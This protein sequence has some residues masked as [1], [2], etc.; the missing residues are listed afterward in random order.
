M[1]YSITPL[2]RRIKDLYFWLRIFEPW[3]ISMIEMADRLNIWL[4]FVNMESRVVG[5]NGMYSIIINSNQNPQEQWEDFGHEV[6]HLLE[7]SGNQLNLPLTCVK[8]Q[9]IQA[10]NF[11]LHFCIPTFMLTKFDLP[12]TVPTAA[13]F[14]SKTFNV[15]YRLAYW[16]LNHLQ[17][18]I[19]G[20]WQRPQAFEQENKEEINYSLHQ[21]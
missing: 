15:T 20:K 17:A 5:R 18:H 6:A 21:L 19:F 14:I 3:E 12:Q 10:E 4:H 7:S 9:E 11:A 2:E 16:K 13:S 8:K 1:Q